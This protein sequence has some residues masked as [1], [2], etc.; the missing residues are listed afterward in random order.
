[1]MTLGL[2]IVITTI[3]YL[4]DRNHV[5]KQAAKTAIGLMLLAGV[6]FGSLI[7][8]TRYQ[9]RKAEAANQARGQTPIQ[10]GGIDTFALV[11]CRVVK[12]DSIS[13]GKETR[14]K[15]EN[16]SESVIA[17]DH[18]SFCIYQPGEQFHRVIAALVKESVYR[19]NNNW[20]GATLFIIE[21]GR[22]P[23][24]P[25]DPAGLFSQKH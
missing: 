10:D 25:K 16:S 15:L 22:P 4:I 11:S 17:T 20:Y 2:A 5:W 18:E 8:W 24:D 14:Y 9:E 13:T 12:D 23:V 19:A 6:G 7:L 3:L 1:M 21:N